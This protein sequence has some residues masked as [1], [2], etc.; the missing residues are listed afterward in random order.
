MAHQQG[1]QMPVNARDGHTLG[2]GSYS[3]IEQRGEQTLDRSR[4]GLR[5]SWRVVAGPAPRAPDS[6]AYGFKPRTNTLWK[7]SAEKRRPGQ[8]DQGG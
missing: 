5:R 6:R 8:I 4:G 2:K 3:S 7:L 1:G